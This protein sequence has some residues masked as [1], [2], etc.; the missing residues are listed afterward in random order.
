[1]F[2]RNGFGTAKV[3]GKPKNYKKN[4][5]LEDETKICRHIDAWERKTTKK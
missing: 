2:P 1:M 3:D 4:Y 5:F